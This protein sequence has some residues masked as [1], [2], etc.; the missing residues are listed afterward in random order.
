MKEFNILKDPVKNKALQKEGFVRLN[1]LGHD[2][3]VVLKKF[4]SQQH[5]GETINGLYVS[6]NRLEKDRALE[7]SA[8]LSE[9][10]KSKVNH[11]IDEVDV[12]GGTFIIKGANTVEKLEPHQDWNIVDESKSRSYTLWIA[13][14]DTND[15]NGALYMLPRSHNTFRGYRHVTIPS[16]YG[17]VYEEVW[18]YMVPVH[19]K[20][21]EGV[22]FDH[23]IGHASMPNRTVND[24]VAVTCSLL[25]KN[26]SYRF[27]CLEDNAISEYF[28]EAEYYQTEE[29]KFGPGNLKKIKVLDEAPYQL[30]RRKLRANYGRFN[31][32]LT[33]LRNL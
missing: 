25:T 29:A 21:G 1:V 30:T 17:K 22:L 20:A 26:S 27:Y 4:K 28:G 9:I 10:L 24:R 8:F 33:Y 31:R 7:I 32:L 3:I 12:L 18:R 13:L 5:V 14:E 15:Q 2:E 16:I 19:L 23:A 6:A 11:L